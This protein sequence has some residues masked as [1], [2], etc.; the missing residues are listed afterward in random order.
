MRA[1]TTRAAAAALLLHAAAAVVSVPAI[2][3]DGMV[4][5]CYNSYD[6]RPLIYGYADPGEVVALN[7]TDGSGNV[8][9][10]FATADTDGFWISQWNPDCSPNNFTVTIQGSA[11]P[12]AITIRDV[13]YGDVFVC[14]GQS[15][16][17]FS[18]KS[19]FVGPEIAAQYYPNIR[20]FPIVQAPASTPQR[21]VPP[22]TGDGTPC[23]WPQNPRAAGSPY[24]CNKWQPA[25]PGITD[26]FSAACFFTALEM[27]KALPGRNIGLVY[28]AYDGTPMQ[29]WSPP[30]ALA[31]C[32]NNA[33]EKDAALRS[34]DTFTDSTGVTITP[35]DPQVLWN[36]MI[37]PVS[38][39]A[40]RAVLWYQGESDSG[41]SSALFSCK[42]QALIESWRRRWRIGDFAWVFVQLAPQDQSRWPQYYM[43]NARLG[44]AG[45]LPLPGDNTT[46]T[47]G[48]APAYDLGD[49][50]SPY[51]PS[52]VHP[53]N[54]TEVGRRLAAALLH[55]QYAYQ[56]PAGGFNLTAST[57]NWRGPVGVSAQAASAGATL[58]GSA[59]SAS[60]SY[61]VKFITLDGL[62]LYLANTAD[63][64][65][66]CAKGQDTFQLSD[67]K[68]LSWVNTTIALAPGD[69]SS[70]I[71]TPVTAGSFTQLRYAPNLWPQC[72]VYAHG[73]AFPA[74]P[75]I[76]N[77]SATAAPVVER[78]SE[79]AAYN[80]PAVKVGSAIPLA[81]RGPNTW[82]QWKGIIIPPAADGI[83]AA[84]PPMGFNTWNSYHCN[85]DENIIRRVADAFVAT[86][87]A[88]L[89]YQ[90]VN[91]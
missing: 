13:T 64:W 89:G 80:A 9:S 22:Y 20:L 76:L 19:D 61:V 7:R 48:M 12:S 24:G 30:E 18:V 75:F 29:A 67:A 11:S 69:N 77:I 31:K 79:S 53:R 2:F 46:D 43:L 56:W 23:W 54:K 86:G 44:Q 81:V 42:F 51:P 68:G 14:S 36:A 15:N 63:C 85:V 55:V 28:G 60:T 3:S 21:D 35:N 6:Q 65:E 1:L 16:M 70:V 45:A 73:N 40:I 52:H 25:A 66:C 26:E 41:D 84:T 10:F 87:L 83:L 5:Q 49:M 58:R 82:T 27:T 62:G 71:I 57:V 78:T 88:Q 34:P 50:G 74:P 90:Y 17:V 47:T 4:L 39:Y 33:A 59:P 8:Q 37:A 91:M 32:P 72:A 38:R